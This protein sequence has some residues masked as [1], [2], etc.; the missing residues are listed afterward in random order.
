MIMLA[1]AFLG[2]LLGL[3]LAIGQVKLLRVYA[4]GKPPEIAQ[5]AYDTID[6]LKLTSFFGLPL[7]FSIVGYMAAVTWFV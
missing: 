5:R 2:A 4:R 7:I 6:N 3:M 1:G